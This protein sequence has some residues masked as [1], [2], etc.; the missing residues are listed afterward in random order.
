VHDKILTGYHTSEL[1]EVATAQ[2]GFKLLYNQKIDRLI[3][4]ESYGKYLLS[5]E[6]VEFKSKISFD[7]DVIEK[8]SIH[9]AFAKD[10]TKSLNA[11]VVVN[12][13]IDLGIG[14]GLYHEV[15]TKNKVPKSMFLS[16][17]DQK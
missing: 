9:V 3:M 4:S 13:A 1:L 7:S 16:S 12:K 11:M 15:M 2:Q 17:L 6:L 14:D 10:I 8:R 5:T